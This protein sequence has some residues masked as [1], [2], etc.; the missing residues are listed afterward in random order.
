MEWM[1]LMVES[2]KLGILELETGG[3][4]P[5]IER[6]TKPSR[7]RQPVVSRV[8][9]FPGWI[10][11]PYT[12]ES[13]NSCRRMP[14]VLRAMTYGRLGVLLLNEKDMECLREIEATQ[15][16]VVLSEENTW[17]WQVG[18]K[19]VINGVLGGLEGLIVDVQK[20]PYL[21]VDVGGAVPFTV[22][23]CLVTRSGL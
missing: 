3:Y 18:E 9:L 6:L 12:P 14:G 4:V 13:Y 7:K 15:P 16:R 23:H 10:F 11:V 20:R 5:R 22:D 19:I 8:P 21:V 1:V 17:D 2:R